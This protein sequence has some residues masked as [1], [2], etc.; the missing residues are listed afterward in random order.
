[1]KKWFLKYQT[2]KSMFEAW[3]EWTVSK[4]SF[5]PTLCFKNDLSLDDFHLFLDTQRYLKYMYMFFSVSYNNINLH[6]FN[7][8]NLAIGL[9]DA[10]MT[11]KCIFLMLIF[12]L[13]AFILWSILKTLSL[14][15][16]FSVP[17]FET[18]TALLRPTLWSRRPK[19]R[20]N[21]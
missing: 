10:Q 13:A 4:H 19:C 5:D 11:F 1:M 14:V 12:E 7:Y 17:H 6:L 2:E 16:T 9:L 20:G 21:I 3:M 18:Y 15:F 8:M